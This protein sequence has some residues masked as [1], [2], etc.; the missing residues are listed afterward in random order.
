V[1]RRVNPRLNPRRELSSIVRSSVPIEPVGSGLPLRCAEKRP[2]LGASSRCV[3]GLANQV[4]RA[5]SVGQR[6]LPY[7]G[8]ET[9]PATM[10]PAP[11]PFLDCR[12][13]AAQ[14]SPRANRLAR[15]GPWCR[16]LNPRR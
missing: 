7:G 14:R 3:A 16:C 13:R 2:L 4:V 15:L 9:W 12:C 1:N 6:G 11:R 5:Q 8:D 10:G